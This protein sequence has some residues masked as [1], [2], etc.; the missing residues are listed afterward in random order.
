MVTKMDHPYF[1]FYIKEYLEETYGKDI[2]ISKGLKVYTTLDPKL[3]NK[4]EEIVQKQVAINRTQYG[5]SSAALISIDNETG[6]ILAMVGGPNYWDEANG[7]NNNM[8]TAK[9]EPGSSF[10][11]IVYSLAISKYPI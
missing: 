4:A 11:P 1:V 3:Q 10:K 6:E 5:A 8:I 9:R 2:D 7:G